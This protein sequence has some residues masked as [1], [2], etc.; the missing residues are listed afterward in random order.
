MVRLGERGQVLVLT[1]GL[2]P[3]LLGMVGMAIDVGTYAA[4]R[5]HAQNAVDSAALALAGD[6]PAQNQPIGAAWLT[7]NG[8][9]S[10]DKLTVTYTTNGPN[11]TVTVTL[12]RM[13]KFAF[14]PVLGINSKGL[15]ASATAIKTSPGDAPG[16]LIPWAVP[17]TEPQ[18]SGASVTLKYNPTNPLPSGEY[19][20]IAIDGTGANVYRT[21]VTNNVTADVLAG[22]SYTNQTGNLAGPTN[23]AV[24]DRIAGTDSRCDTF[25]EVA[26][27]PVAG[28]YSIIPACNP[29]LSGSFASKRLVLVPIT[30]QQKGSYT[31]VSFALFFIESINKAEVTGRFITA[32]V[33]TGARVGI[34]VPGG[35]HWVRLTQ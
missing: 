7:K 16:H 28:K 33:H 11:P 3:C 27:G 31:V 34:Y 12:S 21:D 22:A 32:N 15:S 4:D 9:Q 18:V 19:G 6:L 29:F 14:M 26:Q 20:A 5:Q 1:V 30:T 10:T 17:N 2:F 23:Q 24:G 13:H 25:A 8:I 35:M